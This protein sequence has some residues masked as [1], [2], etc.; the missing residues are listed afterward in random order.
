[1]VNV[2]CVKGYYDTQLNRHVDIDEEFEVTEER[3][4]RL[5]KANV[6]VTT[7]TT[8]KV[9]KGRKKKEV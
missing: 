6:A 3:S 7:T 4:R 2:K 1:M 8:E 5:I 9:A